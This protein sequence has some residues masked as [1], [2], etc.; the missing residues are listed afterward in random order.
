MKTMRL[1][2][3]IRLGAMLKPQGFGD[4][5]VEGELRPGDVLG[6]RS[7]IT[8]CA[9]GAAADAVGGLDFADD[10]NIVE[11]WPW[12]AQPAVRCPGCPSWARAHTGTHD[13]FDVITDLNDEHCWT[14]EQIA[15]WVEGVEH[16]MGLGDTPPQAGEA[17]T[18]VDAVAGTSASARAAHVR[19]LLLF[20][21]ILAPACA[22]RS[23]EPIGN[24]TSYVADLKPELLNDGQCTVQIRYKDG[25]PRRVPVPKEDCE[26]ARR[27]QQVEAQVRAS[28]P[29]ARPAIPPAPKPEPEKK[30]GEQK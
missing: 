5:R 16:R 3:A 4:L 24:F 26:N 20:I 8:T 7:E 12:L 30:P 15:D 14:R 6:L 28:Q 1:S 10:D 19:S 29:A 9:L 13:L 11:C 27:W 23:V 2:H 21:L 17:A 18:H 22:A 25:T